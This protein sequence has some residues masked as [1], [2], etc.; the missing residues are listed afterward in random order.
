MIFRCCKPSSV[1]TSD[2]SRK[3]IRLYREWAQMNTNLRSCIKL[4]T[5]KTWGLALGNRR[6]GS[7]WL[8]QLV[9]NE[10]HHEVEEFIQSGGEF[11][12]DG[13]EVV[14]FGFAVVVAVLAAGFAPAA[15]VEGI[16]QRG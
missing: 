5:K 6:H 8:T 1:Q 3:P 13:G 15:G 9:L 12:F 2:Q 7:L 10:L 11:F 16:D 4:K 14:G